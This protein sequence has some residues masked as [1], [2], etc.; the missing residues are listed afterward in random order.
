MIQSYTVYTSEV[1]VPKIAVEDIQRQLSQI[2]L[3]ENTVG[4][5][6]C[7]YDHVESG[8]MAAIQ[9]ALPF[10]LVGCTTFYKATPVVSGLFELTI[11]ILT[12][13]DVRFAQSS[14]GEWAES[15]AQE[16]IRKTY[17][18]AYQQYGE[19]P[20][21]ILSFISANRPVS[22][23]EYL[24]VLDDASGG[25]PTFGA[26]DSGEDESGMNTYIIGGGKSLHDGLAVL[27]I[28][29]D[30]RARMYVSTP[31]EGSLL[32]F[33]ATVTSAQGVMV[34][35][36]N[37]QPA[38]AYLKKHGVDLSQANETI[39]TS[40]PFYYHVSGSDQYVSRLIQ[41]VMPDGA[42]VFMAEIP[43]GA[44]LRIGT[45]TAGDILQESRKVITHAV[46]RNQDASL[47]LVASCVGRFITLS[48]DTTS[49]MD[50]VVG[51]IPQGIPYMAC[52][53]GGEICPVEKNSGLVNC[54]HN[55]TL[56]VLALR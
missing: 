49:E 29:G 45:L 9:E 16:K 7:H 27:L 38:A 36:I 10:P 11:T 53:A 46:A 22:G 12:S 37:H 13:D 8:V 32:S 28:I 2:P 26:V 48:L 3:C 24:H 44:L 20:A 15:P 21:L 4:I 23:D 17:E 5:V 55:N 14:S 42:L 50:D 6:V 43:E 31:K 18:N 51:R 47:L 41:S 54:Y 19:K 40:M 39:L 52:Y 25:V 33:S 1:D 56:A 34:K 30:I 35:E